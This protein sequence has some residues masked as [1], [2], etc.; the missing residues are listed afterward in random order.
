MESLVHTRMI[1]STLNTPSLTPS[2]LIFS[3]SYMRLGRICPSGLRVPKEEEM[4][5][6]G[7]GLGAGQRSVRNASCASP[8]SLSFS[9]ARHLWA[10]G[11]FKPTTE[12]RDGNV[13]HPD[14]LYSLRCGNSTEMVAIYSMGT[15]ACGLLH[16]VKWPVP[17]DGSCRV[18]GSLNVDALESPAPF[19][20]LQPP[21]AA[22]KCSIRAGTRLN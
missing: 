10:I 18:K 8:N 2:G 15:Y 9:F 1:T 22:L 12:S 5:V 4:R 6:S 21:H 16:R 3:V 11:P 14:V 17:E 7:R 13:T 19:P 20:T